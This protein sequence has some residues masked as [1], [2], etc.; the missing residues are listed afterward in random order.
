[1]TTGSCNALMLDERASL[2]PLRR[3]RPS[4]TK[5]SLMT[6]PAPAFTPHKGRKALT[7]LR[8]RAPFQASA[9]E[10]ASAVSLGS[11][12]RRAALSML[13]ENGPFVAD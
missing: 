12:R 6:L 7:E 3:R 1:M 8:A 13:S 10:T 11:A 5:R 4:P 2:R 9:D